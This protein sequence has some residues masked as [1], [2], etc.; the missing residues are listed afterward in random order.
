[1]VTIMKYILSLLFVVGIVVPVYTYAAAD[2]VWFSPV[3][4]ETASVLKVGDPILVYAK[5]NNVIADPV[6]YVL[7]FTTA[8]TTIGTKVVTVAGYSGQDVS[9]KWIMPA[10]S[11]TVTATI[12]KAT[13]K[14]KKELKALIGPIGTASVS[15]APQGPDIT[16]I[17]GWVGDIVGYLE[18]FRTTQLAYFTTLK[19]E[20]DVVLT[21]TTVKDVTN[22]L[23]PET[24]TSTPETTVQV[25][26]K[27][28]GT[29]L[30]YAKLV[31]ATAGKAFFGHKAAYF[32]AVILLAL[33]IIRLIFKLLLR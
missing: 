26:K 24:P 28:N 8:D 25:E 32:V 4:S 14:N 33:L 22:L 27:D 31:Y 7:A 6:T 13:D 21:R 2:T 9:I 3:P 29:S 12:A 10:T 23:Q 1:M 15:V 17:K 30:G 11:T 5:I 18:S 19:S 20:A 16:P